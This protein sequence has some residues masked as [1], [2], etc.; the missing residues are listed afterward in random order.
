MLDSLGL[1]PV[2]PAS[3]AA[4]PTPS[5]PPPAVPAL[6]RSGAS[7]TATDQSLSRNS[8]EKPMRHPA[9]D[10][11][12]GPPPSFEASLLEL[13]SNLKSVIKRVE[14]A[15]ERAREL[16]AVTLD[17]PS[18]TPSEPPKIDPATEANGTP[19]LAEPYSDEG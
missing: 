15:R 12:P 2:G 8:D 1:N 18:P 3:H 4:R 5:P 13:E 14:A 10:P 16:H 7:G 19:R 9:I 11:V 6:E 17:S